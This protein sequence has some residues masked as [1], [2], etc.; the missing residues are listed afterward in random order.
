MSNQL[1]IFKRILLI[2]IVLIICMGCDQATKSIAHEVLT[3]DRAL[4]YLGDTVRLQLAHNRGAF[5]S[6][7]ASLPDSWRKG[8]FIV[9]AG[10]LLLVLLVVAVTLKTD[11]LF[12]ILSLALLLAGGLSNLLDRIVD[13]GQVIDFIN[14]GIGPLRTGIF[15][16]ADMAIMAGLLIFVTTSMGKQKKG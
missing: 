6:L 9:G 2:L 3:E 13:S 12:P 16:V 14:I 8:A 11:R 1:N 5:L 10:G 7:G 4:S 15:N